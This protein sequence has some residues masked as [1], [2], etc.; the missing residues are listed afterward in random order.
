MDLLDT[1]PAWT[2]AILIFLLRIVDVSLG[3]MRTIWMVHGRRRWA[4]VLGFFEVLIWVVAIAQVVHRVDD[5][6]WLAPFYA[7]GFAAGVA[8]GMTLERRVS[9]RRYV[10]RIISKSHGT[11]IARALHGRGHVLATFPGE[12]RDGRVNL[13]YVTARGHGVEDVLDLARTVDPE[14]FFLVEAATEWSD[15]VFPLPHP[16]GWRAVF[17]KK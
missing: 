6:P 10:V 13:V 11:E 3:T 9:A 15:N 7:G 4:V 2:V 5:A 14:M 1:F 12:T 8:V 17:K 16:T